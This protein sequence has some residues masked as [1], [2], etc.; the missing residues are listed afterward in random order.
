[1]RRAVAAA[2][3]AL[4]ISAGSGCGGIPS[5]ARTTVLSMQ[6][7]DSLHGAVAL[8]R[9]VSAQD[10]VYQVALDKGRAEL[11]V[12]TD[13][14]VDV[15]AMAGRL[16]DPTESFSLV[17]G[18]GHGSYRSWETVVP[19]ADVKVLNEGGADVPELQSS[20]AK[21]KVTI[22]DFA[23]SW[24][25]PCRML[26]AYVTQRL[27]ARRDLAYRK[28]DI[29]DWDSPVATHYMSDVKALP[30]VIV[31]GKDGK[32]VDRI[33]GLDMERLEA[34]IDVGARAPGPEVA[35]SPSVAPGASAAP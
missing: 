7:L 1:M 33:A 32:E 15:L 4:A 25:S 34:A 10:G 23:A 28:I 9:A 17:E 22:V 3:F 12:L 27:K 19:D 8:A 24:C 26:D 13:P 30:Y 35:P 29:L 16:R 5:N 6:G 14:G 2:L 21:G 20:L 18:A 11:R 31:F